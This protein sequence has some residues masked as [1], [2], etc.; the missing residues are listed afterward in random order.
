MMILVEGARY[1]AFQHAIDEMH[2]LRARVFDDRLG[3]EVTV[4][5]GREVDRFDDLR[6][7]YLIRTDESGI[8]TACV[9]LLPTTGSNMLRDVF[10]ELAGDKG[11]PASPRI[12]ESSRFCVDHASAGLRQG[13][14][15]ATTFELFAAMIE[16]GLYRGAESIV[17]VTDL[18]M[19]KILVRAGWPL[20]RLADPRQ[21]GVTKAVAGC[22]D[23]TTS[24]LATV[25]ERGG[26]A[27]SPVLVAP[28]YEVAA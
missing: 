6:P 1:H 13:G 17:T 9:R 16:Y 21:I 14:L 5:N 7:D 11:A 26:L 22:V 10:P 27:S 23:I 2:R 12:W 3:W 28:V 24:A 18:R 19:E 15:K 25:R 8:A 4:E 20:H